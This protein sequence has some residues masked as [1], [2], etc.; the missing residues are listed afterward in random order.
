MAM[1]K[2]ITF[3]VFYFYIVIIME[4]SKLFVG[5]I[6]W[7]LEWQELKDIFKEYGEVVYVKIIKD[8]ETGKSKGF[9]FIEFASVEEA[10][11]AKEAMDGAEVDGRVIN[12]DYAQE[13]KEA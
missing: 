2:K 7:N 10:V 1:L 11:K 6:S 12:V 13:R 3:L 5:G 4:T 9:G 8:R